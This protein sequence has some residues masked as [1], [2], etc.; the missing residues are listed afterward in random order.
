METSVA[1][2]LAFVRKQR[3]LRADS[4]VAGTCADWAD[5]RHE[6]GFIAALDLLETEITRGNRADEG[7]DLG[8]SPDDHRGDESVQS[9]PLQRPSRGHIR[10]PQSVYDEDRNGRS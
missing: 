2:I 9:R 7:A 3:A 6:I 10:S 4:V 5:Y 1:A 8:D